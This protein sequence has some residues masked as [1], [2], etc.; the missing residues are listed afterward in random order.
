M[1][2]AN[3]TDPIAVSADAANRWTEGS[4]DVWWFRGNCRIQQGGADAGCREAVMWIKRADDD[5]QPESKIIAYLEGDVE[6]T[7]AGQSGPIKVKDQ[8]WLGRF[9]TDREIQVYAGQAAQNLPG[10]RRYTSGRW[11]VAI[12]FRPTR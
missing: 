9:E 11:S 2:E 8:T 4:Y 12:R 5:R 1:P 6:V 7:R 3:H 10:C